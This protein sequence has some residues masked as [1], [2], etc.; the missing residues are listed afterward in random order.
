MHSSNSK[1]IGIALLSSVAVFS[2]V[3]AQKWAVVVIQTDSALGH[4]IRGE[5]D[6]IFQDRY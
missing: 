5:D 6:I 1:M 4:A 2:P 3:Q